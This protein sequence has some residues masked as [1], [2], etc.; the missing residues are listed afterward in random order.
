MLIA[1]P[2]LRL[3]LLSLTTIGLI[4]LNFFGEYLGAMCIAK[5]KLRKKL[6]WFYTAADD[7]LTVFC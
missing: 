1:P 5:T 4:V 6:Q 7:L 3:A 2:F